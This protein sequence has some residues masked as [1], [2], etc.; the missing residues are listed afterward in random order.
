[1]IYFRSDVPL[2]RLY[3]R[4]GLLNGGE[5]VLLMAVRLFVYFVFAYEKHGSWQYGF[6]LFFLWGALFAAVWLFVSFLCAGGCSAHSELAS[7]FV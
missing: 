7:F 3:C 2:A 6:L 5:D 1:M 4:N